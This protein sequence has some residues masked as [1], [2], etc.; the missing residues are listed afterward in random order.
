[1]SRR[2]IGASAFV[3]L[4][5]LAVSAW[6]FSSRSPQAASGATSL[7]YAKALNLS[8]RPGSIWTANPDG[9]GPV[10]VTDG[11]S[12]ELSPNGR[13]IAFVRT[14]DLLLIPAVGGLTRRLQRVEGDFLGEPV[15]AP[16]SRRLVSL[17]EGGHVKPGGLVLIDARSGRRTRFANS[18]RSKGVVS[19]PSFSPDSGQIVYRRSDQTG[20]DLYVYTIASGKTRKI[21]DD[22]RAFE[23]LW[24]PHAIAYND[25]GFNRSGDVW[26]VR[27]DGT[28]A[29]RLTHTNAGIYPAAWSASGSRL[30]AA[31]PATHN[32]RL[33]AVVLPTGRSR[34][35]TDWVGDLFPQGLSSDGRTVLA[36][37]GCGGLIS[38][39][40]VVETLPFAGGEPKV[41]VKG[42]CRANW[43]R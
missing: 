8:G 26:L 7:V 23:P 37:I 33:W 43:N 25:G 19:T 38:P 3:A 31:N 40:G 15:W 18:S 20:G 29:R 39:Y 24:G 4:A 32:G 27:G 11:T 12:P 2:A 42:P 6:V 35:L 36:A 1:M 10:H 30:L 17:D 14:S 16:D 9:S 22:H 21:T 34:Q 5:A 13:W 41:I 28:S